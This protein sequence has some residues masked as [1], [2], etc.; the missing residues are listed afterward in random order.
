LRFHH[1]D[2]IR[3]KLL[4][5]LSKAYDIALNEGDR[6]IRH[7]KEE[8]LK[9]IGTGEFRKKKDIQSSSEDMARKSA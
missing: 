3:L 8:N 6:L 5:N 1:Y 2:A 4:A 9:L 7:Y